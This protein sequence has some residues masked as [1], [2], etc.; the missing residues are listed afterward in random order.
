MVAF[1]AQWR[2]I[3]WQL[4]SSLSFIKI[5]LIMYWL[6]P[7]VTS[8]LPRCPSLLLTCGHRSR[9][10][11]PHHRLSLGGWWCRQHPQIGWCRH[12]SWLCQH[13]SIPIL[14]RSGLAHDSADSHTL[15]TPVTMFACK[16]PLL[17][18]FSS[19]RLISSHLMLR[20]AVSCSCS[21]SLDCFSTLVV[22]SDRVYFAITQFFRSI[23]SNFF[24]DCGPVN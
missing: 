8:L 20:S 18:A 23:Y 12:C 19:I 22:E 11:R 13:S 4:L 21:S 10:S 24:L 14:P 9:E 15:Q 17:I 6:K 7:L 2:M 5:D 1:V 16:L 3:S